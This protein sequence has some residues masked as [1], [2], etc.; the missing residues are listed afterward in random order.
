MNCLWFHKGGYRKPKSSLKLKYGFIKSPKG[1]RFPRP[2][3]FLPVKTVEQKG[4]TA[5]EKL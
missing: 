1:H 3:V 2:E 4:V 5:N